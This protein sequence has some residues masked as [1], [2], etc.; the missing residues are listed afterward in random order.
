MARDAKQPVDE[1]EVQGPSW[2]LASEYAS[3]QCAALAAD[4]RALTELL[5]RIEALN[6][7]LVAA[8]PSAAT[9][10]VAT[11]QPVIA[12]AQEVFRLSEKAGPL[13]S[14]PLTYANCLLSVDAQDEAAQVLQGRLQNFQKRYGELLE[15]WSEILDLV[16]DDIVE[17][18]PGR[19]R[20][21]P[22]PRSPFVTVANDATNC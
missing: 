17:A 9:L 15:P 19:S 5:D 13:L 20:P 7:A 8:L 4:L 14:N 11:A 16:P 22:C 3:P 18:Y 1:H 21:W 12:T 10:D 2:D 6:P